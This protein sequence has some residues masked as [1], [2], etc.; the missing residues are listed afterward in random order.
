MRIVA[1]DVAILAGA[2]LRFVGVHDEIMRPVLHFLRH[3]RPF[4]AGGEARAATAAQAGLLHLVD[5]GVDAARQDLLGAV[6]RAA[7]TG[8]FETPIVE[9]V[10]VG[11]DA[12]LVG[13]HGHSPLKVVGPPSGAEVWRLTCGPGLGVSPRRK[14]SSTFFVEASSRS[15]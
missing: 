1:Q 4:E 13:K 9:A 10:E 14:A 2:G 15:S 12:V 3:E 11:E 6:P 7:L 8:A 5:D